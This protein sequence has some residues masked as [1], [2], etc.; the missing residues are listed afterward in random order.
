MRLKKG[1]I[2]PL[3]ALF[4]IIIVGC[5]GPRRPPQPA[6]AVS[7][8]I[9]RMGGNGQ[10]PAQ[11]ES[12]VQNETQQNTPVQSSNTATECPTDHF[13][14]VQPVPT[15]AAYPNPDLSVTCAED[16]FVINSNGIPNFEFIQITP[17]DLTPQ[18]YRWE[19]PLNPQPAAEPTALPRLG[20]VAVAVNGVPIYGPERSRPAGLG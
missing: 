9:G 17:N 20:T 19:I 14:N 16:V 18:N 13:L 15:N 1:L 4:L 6:Q 3:I 7:A 10:A 2:F 8:S 11:G 12:V 5:A